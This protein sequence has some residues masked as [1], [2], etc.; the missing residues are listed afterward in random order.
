MESILKSR[1]S[2]PQVKDWFSGRWQTFNEQ[3]I[4]A[5]D[6]EGKLFKRRPDRVMYDDG[7]VVVVDFKFGH[8]REEHHRQVAEY[9]QL[10]RDMGYPRVSGFLWFVYENRVASVCC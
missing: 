7:E 5:I 10:L 6:N 3:S 1:F 2:N 9:V 8:E 4:I